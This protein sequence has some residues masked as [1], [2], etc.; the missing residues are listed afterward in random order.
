MLSKTLTASAE[1]PPGPVT[2]AS[3]PPP[4][5]EASARSALIGSSSVSVSPSP[6]IVIVS[7][8]AVPS[9]DG[10]GPESGVV[11]LNGASPAAAF[12][13]RSWLK[14]RLSSAIVRAVGS[15]QPALAPV[16]DDGRGLLAA[17]AAPRRPASALVDSASPGRN[18]VDSFFSASA[19]LPGRL[20]PKTQTITT[21]HAARTTNFAVRPE[22]MVKNRAIVC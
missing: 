20:K 7:S 17:L 5:L 22:G 9:R 3:R 1:K 15:A 8:A 2:L 16:D 18:D 19:Y 6:V 14:F 11:A 10:T 13:S 12:S 4:G 21:I